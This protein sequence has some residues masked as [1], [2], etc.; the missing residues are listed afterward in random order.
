MMCY[1]YSWIITLKNATSYSLENTLELNKLRE[2]N[3]VENGLYF[4]MWLAFNR[5]CFYAH[6][7]LLCQNINIKYISLNN[8]QCKHII[9]YYTISFEN[10][11]TFIISYLE[12]A[13]AP[14]SFKYIRFGIVTYVHSY[15]TG[16]TRASQQTINTNLLSLSICPGA[17]GLW[18]N[19]SQPKVCSRFEISGSI[20]TYVHYNTK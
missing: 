4:E 17:A 1:T 9:Y 13:L 6:W 5:E 11:I 16:Y 18:R 2:M 10:I 15:R 8:T 7:V 3:M 12:L 14:H 19:S 20:Q